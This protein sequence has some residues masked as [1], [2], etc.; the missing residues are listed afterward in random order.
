MIKYIS[1]LGN[2]ASIDELI[3]EPQLD[4]YVLDEDARNYYSDD[5]ISDI[6]LFYE[7]EIIDSSLSK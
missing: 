4:A 6:E 3:Y 5:A 7:F 1:D 2:E